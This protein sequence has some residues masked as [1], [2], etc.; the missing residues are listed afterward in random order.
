MSVRPETKHNIGVRASTSP[1]KWCNNCRSLYSTQALATPRTHD[2][3]KVT[4]LYKLVF[5]TIIKRS[6]WT[7]NHN[8]VVTKGPLTYSMSM[9][10]Y[11]ILP[12][13]TTCPQSYTWGHWWFLTGYL[14]VWV[15]L[16]IMDHIYVWFLI[17]VPFFSSVAWIEVC[18]EHHVLKFILGGHWQFVSG[19]IF[20]IMNQSY[21]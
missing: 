21:G 5:Y 11:E 14:E 10:R 2:T 1:Y 9:T 4:S 6:K 8:I 18:Q 17:C 12:L 15:I 19:V 20:D 7:V 3:N 16:E 13:R